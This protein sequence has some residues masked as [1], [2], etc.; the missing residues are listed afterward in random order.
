MSL[1]TRG[2]NPIG[3]MFTGGGMTPGQTIGRAYADFGRTIGATALDAASR[4]Q[5]RA[6]E[7][8]TQR[9]SEETRKVL[10]QYAGNPTGL[11]AKGQELSMSRD[12]KMAETGQRF[13][14]IAQARITQQTAASDKETAELQRQGELRL[15]DLARTMGA[16]NK[17]IMNND[18][19]RRAYLN[20]AESFKVSP[21]RAMEIAKNAM[22]KP[23]TVTVGR[24]E[25]LG[26]IG[27]DGQFE[28]IATGVGET[29]EQGRFKDV[30]MEDGSIMLYN[31]LTG[32]NL[33][34]PAD[35]KDQGA[36][37]ELI[38][39]TAGYINDVDTLLGVDPKDM[40]RQ[41]REPGF[42]ESGLYAQVFSRF[43][44]FAA[45]DRQRLIDEVRA[46]LGFEQIDEMKRQ[47]EEM[48]AS[49]TGL[50]QISNIEFNSLQS[51]VAALDVSMTAEAQVNAL[52]KI[53]KHLENIQRTA[54]GITAEQ[55]IDWNTPKY[56]ASGYSQDPKSGKVFY[57]P[58][59]PDGEKFYLDNGKFV[60]I[61]G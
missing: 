33:T 50:G 52:I 13:I 43:G 1:F 29:P 20:V 51:T 32:Q 27:E 28:E 40:T 59:G 48:G 4:L 23:E 5:K 17:D 57:A 14:Q 19:Q 24:F 39:R 8:E 26:R 41:I 38:Q 11:L 6:D 42:T 36:S 16:Q 18:L 61:G 15:M 22:V 21:A 30:K 47:A 7:K 54:S 35:V 2:S 9:L 49:G 12:P 25:R 60:P 3:S 58:D 45:R 34:I 56:K 53:R 31:D 10:E 55:T 46:R 37:F 44:G